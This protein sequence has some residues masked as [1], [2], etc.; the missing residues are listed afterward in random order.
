MLVSC[1]DVGRLHTRLRAEG[2]LVIAYGDVTPDRTDLDEVD[3]VR[4]EGCAAFLP[5]APVGRSTCC[6]LSACFL[7]R[8][9]RL[10]AQGSARGHEA[11]A[12]AHEQHDD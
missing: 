10:D 9:R 12:Q 4:E 11:R 2:L 8:V 1:Q 6:C 5:A 3:P 7:E